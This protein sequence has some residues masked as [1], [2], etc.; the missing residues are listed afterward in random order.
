M[1]VPEAVP[2]DLLG[3]GQRHFLHV[4]DLNGAEFR[5]VLELAKAIKPIV[6][7]RSN[8]YKPFEGQTLSMVFCKPSTR[9][10]VSFESG[11]YRLGGHALCLGEEIGIGKREATKDIS[12]VLASMNDLVMAR[13]FGHEQILELAK[14]SSVPVINGLTD[15]NHPC[16]IVADALTIEEVFGTIEGKKVVYVGDGNNIVHSWL[17]LACIVPFEFVCACPVGFE[18]DADLLAKV[19]ASGVGSACVLN[20]P[21]EAVKGADVIYA[22]VW[23]SMGQKDEAEKRARIFADFQV[24]EAMM[25]ATGKAETI[26]LHCLPAERGKETTDAV[27]ESANSHIFQ[28]AENRMHAQNAIMVFCTGSMRP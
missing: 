2:S 27:L 17:E 15:H 9:T 13:L 24:N 11:Y 16:Q 10:R 22:D 3:E 23:A 12:R 26:F 14:Y 20:D 28:Q 18:P 1:A 25:A 4:D 21:M 7:A 19:A 6:K 8:T 5:E